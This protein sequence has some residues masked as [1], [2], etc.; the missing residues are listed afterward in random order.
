[1]QSSWVDT[2]VGE[3]C[4]FIYGK[5]LPA[6]ARDESGST[7]VYGSGGIS[8]YH[9]KSHVE[10]PGV[11]IGRKGT[12]G[13]VRFCDGPFWPIDTTFYVTKEDKLDLLFTYYLLKSLGLEKLNSDS[14]VPGLNREE[15]H[16]I[17]IKVPPLE[18]RRNIAKSISCYDN[19]INLNLEVNQTLEQ[20]AQSLFK[21]WFVDFDPVVDNALA[22]GNP[23]PDELAHRVEVRKK[24][25]ALPDF[26]PLPE[27]I[28]N[29]FPSEFEQTGEVTFGIEGWIP[30]GWE[31]KKFKEV[32]DKYIDNRGKTPPLS[33]E[34]YPLVEVKNLP[35]NSNFPLTNSEKRVDE[36]TFR[37][38]FRQYVRE[39]DIL[40]STV[41]TIGR[42]SFVKDVD[43]GVAQNV[44]GLRFGKLATPEFMFYTIKGHRFQHDVDSRLVITVQASI[45]RKDL[46]TIDILLPNISIQSKFSEIVDGYLTAQYCRALQNQTLEANRD[47]LLPKL[48]SG[49][50]EL[51]SA[52]KSSAN[53]EAELQGV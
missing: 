53:Q 10:H 20:M 24:A 9:S 40:I 46:N 35:A 22:A 34:G 36:K 2:T 49:E 29:L 27:H 38:W 4:P 45:K 50:I 7:P 12:V 33:K 51:D 32:I 1:M 11:I 18:V 44:L 16:S 25:H 26:Q 3:F 42:S 31:H 47:A 6:R 28:R 37:S 13:S 15:A 23:I 48:I 41:G 39:K 8:G 5:S 30:K 17:P 19:K 43:I 52:D 21:S 14:A